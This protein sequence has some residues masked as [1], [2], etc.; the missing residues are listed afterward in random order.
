MG[1][2]GQLHA[3]AALTAQQWIRGWLSPIAGIDAVAKKESIHCSSWESNSG[4]PARNLVPILTELPRLTGK[5][6]VG[7]SCLISGDSSVILYEGVSK[8]FRT[9]RLER[10]LRMVQLSATRCSCIAIL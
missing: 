1:M 10:E 7:I 3:P 9:G 4:R 8:S 6:F 2:S 5:E